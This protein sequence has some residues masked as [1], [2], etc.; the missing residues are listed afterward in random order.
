MGNHTM[1]L[2]ELAITSYLFRKVV[3][4]DESFLA[5]RRAVG[6][7]LDLSQPDHRKA[8]LRWLNKWGCRQ[9]ARAYHEH[10]SEEIRAWYEQDAAILPAGDV[11]LSTLADDQVGS[12]AEAYGR[13]S[14]R[15]AS[16]RNDEVPVAVGPVGAA[17]ILFAAKPRAIPPWD[18]RI[19]G[20]F[21]LDGSSESYAEWVRRVQVRL[22]QLTAEAQENGFDLADF[23]AML[24]RPEVTLPKL[25]DEYYWLTITRGVTLPSP[26]TLREWLA[27]V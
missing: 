6:G 14:R 1:N 21:G 25:I 18:D 17:K 15:I 19:R 8:L 4:F 5:F 11:D 2:F 26:D 10:A 13:L 27:L 9:F 7:N 20:E 12:V 23:P 22:S 24:G 3:D 16:F